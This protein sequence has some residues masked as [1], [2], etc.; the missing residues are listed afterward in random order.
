MERVTRICVAWSLVLHLFACASTSED[1]RMLGGPTRAIFEAANGKT[2][3][4]FDVDDGT[5]QLRGAEGELLAV[6]RRDADRLL[7]SGPAPGRQ[8]IIERTAERRLAVS[9]PEA[10]IP[11]YS[12]RVDPDG[13]LKVAGEDGERL[14]VAKHRDYGYKIVSG[15]GAMLGKLR[16]RSGKHSLRD[17]SGLTYLSTHAPIPSASVALLSLEALPLDVAAGLAAAVAIWPPE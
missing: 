10:E 13:D 17:D 5:L 1:D 15:D 2:A 16:S 3:L 9:R 4:R 12:L 11:S 7:V 14:A 8:W 6:V